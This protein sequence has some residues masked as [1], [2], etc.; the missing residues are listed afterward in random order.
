MKESFVIAILWLLFALSHMVLSSRILRPKLVA[1]MGEKRFI[2]VY[3][4]LAFVFFAP[5]AFYAFTHLHSGPLIWLVIDIQEIRYLLELMNVVGFVLVASG[6]LT[7]SPSAVMGAPRDEPVGVQRITRHPVF[8]GIGIWGFAHMVANG[9]LSDV[10]FFGG[11]V[12]FVLIGCWHQD[13]RKLEGSDV[14]FKKFHAA[15]AFIPFTKR[16]AVRGLKELRLV[17]VIAGVAVALITRFLH[18]SILG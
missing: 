8:M 6:I 5:L 15:T 7:P 14:Q 13:Q 4:L 10:T 3:S 11:F 17:A 9:F 16:G 12:I 2:A 1:L 18:P